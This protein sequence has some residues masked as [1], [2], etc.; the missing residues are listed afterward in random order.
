MK[1]ISKIQLV[2]RFF[3][4]ATIY[5][6]LYLFNNH[7]QYFTPLNIP[8]TQIDQ[9]IPFVPWGVYIYM[10]A[11]LQPTFS[12]LRLYRLENYKQLIFLQNHMLITAITA[13]IIFFFLPTT[14]SIPYAQYNIDQFLQLTD[15]L[16]AS[17]LQMIYKT[18]RPFNCLPSLHVAAAFVAAIA[19]I[20]DYKWVV[21]CSFFFS[22]LVALSTMFVKQHIFY[23]VIFGFIL[24]IVTIPLT[25]YF[26]NK[27]D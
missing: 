1:K 16:T 14:I 11:Y 10:A 18:D 13:N 2:I 5:F 3:S 9:L 20:K 21:L 12:F 24:S 17:I 26:T 8:L 27:V 4:V 7:F 6:S 15:P 25:H 19:L 23:D 22:L